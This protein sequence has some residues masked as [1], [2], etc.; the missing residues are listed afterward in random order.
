MAVAR[1]KKS[2]AERK[3]YT[4]DY[5][6]WLEADEIISGLAVS[7]TPAT[8]PVLEVDGSYIL[9]SNKGVAFYVRGGIAGS[10][11]A[12]DLIVSTSTGQIK[13]D[14]VTMQVVSA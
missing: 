1:F 9:P 3:Q 10:I 13:E 6:S 4:V 14:V 12:V 2:P 8:D 7:V 11:Y 5:T